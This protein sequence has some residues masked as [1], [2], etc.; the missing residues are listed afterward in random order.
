M[1]KPIDVSKE[2]FITT[3]DNPFDYFSQFDEWF[4]FDQSHGYHTL[5]YV[6]R[7]TRLAPD[8]S[9]EDENLEYKRVFD[10]IIEWNGDFYKVIYKKD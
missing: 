2:F 5:E 3:A 6:A 10:S 8:L 4:E 1:N 9:E 7:L